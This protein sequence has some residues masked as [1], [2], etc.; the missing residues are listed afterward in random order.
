MVLD[1]LREAETFLLELAGRAN[2][3]ET[4]GALLRAARALFWDYRGG[5]NAIDDSNALAAIDDMV[6]RGIPRAAAI[7]TTA[8]RMAFGFIHF[9]N[10]ALAPGAPS[11]AELLAHPFKVAP[12]CSTA[13]YLWSRLDRPLPSWPC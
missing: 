13:I 4:R 6:A 11:A 8:H 2:F 10:C 1:P 5:Q 7:R 3:P 9:P 12:T